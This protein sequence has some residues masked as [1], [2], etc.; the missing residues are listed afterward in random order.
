MFIRAGAIYMPILHFGLLSMSETTASFMGRPIIAR[1]KRL[2]FARPAAQTLAC[3][4][5]DIPQVIANVSIFDIVFYFMARFQLDA[6]KFFT[7]WFILVVCTLCLSSFYRMIGAWCRHF[8]VASQ[9]TGWCTMIM[10]VYAGEL[11]SR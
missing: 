11:S 4:L 10:M 7:H 6:G 2:A 3:T 9:I 5:A 8:G 1:H